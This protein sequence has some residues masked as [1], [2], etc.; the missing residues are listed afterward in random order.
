MISSK[1]VAGIVIAAANQPALDRQT[2]GPTNTSTVHAYRLDEADISPTR[3]ALMV[4]WNEFNY[5]LFSPAVD[6]Q[7]FIAFIVILR[8]REAGN[9]STHRS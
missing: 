4:G 7:G 1:L 3:H 8:A 2:D 6:I 5:H 9:K